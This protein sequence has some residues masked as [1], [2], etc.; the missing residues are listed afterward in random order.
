VKLEIAVG[1]LGGRKG[2]KPEGGNLG[3]QEEIC[4]ATGGSNASLKL[5]RLYCKCPLGKGTVKKRGGGPK[6]IR[7]TMQHRVK[8]REKNVNLGAMN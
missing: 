8:Q 7:G 3:E 4:R 5:G 6:E 1:V 2:K